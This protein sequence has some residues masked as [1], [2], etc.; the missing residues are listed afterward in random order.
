M[1]HFESFLAP[2]IEQYLLYRQSLGYS[3]KNIRSPLLAFDR[4]L[5]E[6]GADWDSLHPAFFLELREKIHK[7]PRTVNLTLSAV[8]GFFQF[9]VRKGTHIENPLQDVPPVPERYFV[10]FVFSPDQIERLLVAVCNSIRRNEKCFLKEMS[11]Y[12]AILLMARCGVRISE[13]LRLMLSH[14]RRDD[15]TVYIEKTKFKKDR[16]IP[17]SK[18]VMTEI[19]NYLALRNSLCRDNKN[20]YLLAD[21]EQKPLRDS[22]VRRFFHQAVRLTGLYQP[23]QIIGD[24]TFGSPTPHSLRHSFAINTL[25]SIKD[26]GESPQHALPVLAAYMGHREYQY[27]G[28]Y[29]KVRDAKHLAGLIEFSKSQ[30]DVI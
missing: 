1:K 11:L 19:E 15:G 13:P 26:R 4:Y 8:R 22:Q 16:L 23:K 9:L 30:L 3:I 28:A 24:L 25:K 20:P 14:Y 6:Q 12:M 27:T 2:Q 18:A 21:K 5:K 10:P 29:L 17:V 7:N